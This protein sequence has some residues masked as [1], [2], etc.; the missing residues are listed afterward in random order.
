[1]FVL[2]PWGG[3]QPRDFVTQGDTNSESRTTQPL[4]KESMSLVTVRVQ[5]DLTDVVRPL[6]SQHCLFYAE[7]AAVSA[8][9]LSASSNLW[10][11]LT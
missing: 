3:T 7:P 4:K 8:R 6:V 11:V 10:L 9:Q 1:M 2:K 5:S